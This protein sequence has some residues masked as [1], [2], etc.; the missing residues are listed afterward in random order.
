MA[1]QKLLDSLNEYRRHY[2]GISSSAIQNQMKYLDLI[3]DLCDKRQVKALFLN[4]P[5]TSHN[6]K[7]LESEFYDYYRDSI[8]SIVLH[9]YRNTHFLDLNSDNY[10]VDS[11]FEDS[12][13]LNEYGAK[14][15]QDQINDFIKN[16]DILEL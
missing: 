12:A 2:S 4:M 15:L 7:L 3:A 5:L 11:D 14:K 6:K 8:K 9:N 1:K 10:F 16:H 13:H